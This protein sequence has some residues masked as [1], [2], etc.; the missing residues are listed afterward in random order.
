[1]KER[2]HALTEAAVIYHMQPPSDM[3]WWLCKS[4]ILE[5][6]V[7]KVTLCSVTSECDDSLTQASC[8][9][10]LQLASFTEKSVQW[11]SDFSMCGWRFNVILTSKLKITGYIKGQIVPLFPP[12]CSL[13]VISLMQILIAICYECWYSWINGL[14][15]LNQIISMHVSVCAVHKAKLSFKCVCNPEWLLH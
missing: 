14:I 2:R 12:V 10:I 9:S 13:S 3:T 4:Q 6:G 11:D 5:A 15:R 8:V 1:M 7:F